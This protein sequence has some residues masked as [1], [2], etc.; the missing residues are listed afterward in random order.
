MEEVL[1]VDA[2]ER[3]DTS[4]VVVHYHIHELT[5]HGPLHSPKLVL[6]LEPTLN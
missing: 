1:R 2:E 3:I 6:Q 4:A 5:S